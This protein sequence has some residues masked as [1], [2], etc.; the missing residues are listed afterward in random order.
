MLT[1]NV[2]IG[3]FNSREIE[4]HNIFDHWSFYADCLKNKKKNG[5]DREA[6]MEQLRRDLMYYYWSKC[7]WEIILQHW[8]TREDFRDEKVDVYDQVR[9]N[10]HAFTDYVWNNLKELKRLPGNISNES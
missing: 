9:L 8:P 3:N 7:E 10:W 4:I 2:Y 6:F 5:K 1:W